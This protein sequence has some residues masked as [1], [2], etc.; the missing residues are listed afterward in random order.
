MEVQQTAESGEAQLRLQ[1]RAL[2]DQLHRRH[3]DLESEYALKTQELKTTRRRYSEQFRSLLHQHQQIG[4][5][6]ATALNLPG[7]LLEQA[8][9]LQTG[10]PA[11]DTDRRQQA[12]SQVRKL[13][14]VRGTEL[15]RFIIRYDELQKHVSV[16]KMHLLDNGQAMLTDGQLTQRVSFETPDEFAALCFEASKA[17]EEPRPLVLILMTYG[18][19]Q[20]GFRRSATDG[21]PLLMHRLRDDAGGTRWFDFSLMGFRPDGPLLDPETTREQ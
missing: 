13:L 10:G 21:L 17:F 8:L 9:R 3:R 5:A 14:D 1:Q 15:L 11:G 12:I 6:L 19:T 4:T 2:N 16:W 7:Q 18:D 20:T